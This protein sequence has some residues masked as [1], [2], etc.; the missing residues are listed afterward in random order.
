MQMWISTLKSDLVVGFFR[1]ELFRIT[2]AEKFIFSRHLLGE[3]KINRSRA[4][5]KMC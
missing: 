4:Q 3:C 1:F 2:L 5:R